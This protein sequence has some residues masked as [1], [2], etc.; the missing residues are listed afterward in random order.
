V[1]S[2]VLIVNP[3]ASRVTPKLVTAVLAELA[4][5]GPVE[6][7]LTE[8]QGHAAELAAEACGSYDEI[9][10][11][12]GDGGYNEAVNGMLPSVPIGFLPGGAT[13]VLPRALGLPRDPVECARRLARSREMRR[14]SLGVANG[15]RFT[16]CVG[17]GLDAEL[18]RAVDRR[19]RRNGK[20]PHDLAFV[21][22]LTRILVGRRGRLEPTLEVEG[23]GRCAFVVTSNCDPYTFAG[24]IPVHATPE[25]S[26]E[27][28]LDLVG[29]R[30]V[31]P[32]GFA[33][34]AWSVLVHPTHQRSE[35]YLYIHD[36]DA[37]RIVCDGRLPVQMDGEDIGDATEVELGV[38]R[39]ALTVHV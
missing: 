38:E 8:R 25:A 11:L 32:F 6:K 12:S 35:R 3:M 36:A 5:A 22:E 26:F 17:V 2:A 14:I 21:W 15:R 23:H 29:P 24:P 30:R 37:L 13:S 31:G 27:L 1:R 34:L 28:G 18:V 9:V 20:R 19:G 10:V 16:F 4:A 39:D 7:V 33:H